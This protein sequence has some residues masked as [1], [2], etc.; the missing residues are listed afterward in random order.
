MDL[1]R[2]GRG[3]EY[4]TQNAV[5]E[6]AEYANYTS[7]LEGMAV[8]MQIAEEVVDDAKRA[9]NETV[10]LWNAIKDEDEV[11]AG[12]HAGNLARCAHRL[13]ALSVHLS[14]ASR[15]YIDRFPRSDK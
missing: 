8:I 12:S 5:D 13:A 1:I 11:M 14:A 7:E 6:Q 9:G 15:L 2:T 4:L 10:E 3:I